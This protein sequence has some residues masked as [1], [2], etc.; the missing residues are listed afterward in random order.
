MIKGIAA[1][2]SA[3]AS[4]GLIII[5]VS[6]LSTAERA[7]A[8]VRVEATEVSVANQPRPQLSCKDFEFWF[9][10]TSCPKVR[11]KHA[12]RTKHRVATYVLAIRPAPRLQQQNAREY[13]RRKLRFS[14]LRDAYGRSARAFGRKTW[15]PSFT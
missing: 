9:L 7:F 1:I 10:S 13:P 8:T 14:M 3:A 12:A 2:I 15:I 5:L 6:Q 4:I 11:A